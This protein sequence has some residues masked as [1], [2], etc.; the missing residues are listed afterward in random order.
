M[1]ADWWIYVMGLGA[2]QIETA[3]HWTHQLPMPSLAQLHMLVTGMLSTVLN[4]F[5]IT[6]QISILL[7][8]AECLMLP[9]RLCNQYCTKDI[10]TTI[11][12]TQL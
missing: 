8:T 9:E 10:Y 3:P 5:Q 1:Q 2:V 6:V 7:S 12:H 4:V 11:Q